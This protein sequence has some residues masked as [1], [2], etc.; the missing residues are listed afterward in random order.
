M[1]SLAEPLP[2]PPRLSRRRS[3]G[4]QGRIA[5]DRLITMLVLAGLLH[6]LIILGVSFTT[7]P[8]RGDGANRGLE[9][10]LVSDELPEARSNDSAT[11]LAQRTQTG[12]G[13]TRERLPAKLPSAARPEAGAAASEA[14]QAAKEE[15]QLLT[16]S[17]VTRTRVHMVPLLPA[18]ALAAQQ[19][20]AAQRAGDQELRLRGEARD[21]LYVTADTRASRLAPYL[22]SWR[23]RVERIGTVNYPTVAQRRGMG[24]NPV[25]EV[26][27]QSD[28]KLKSA[29]ILQ[30]SGHPEID[31]AALDILRLASPFDAFPAELARDYRSL[32][33]AYEWQFGD[34]GTPSGLV[35]IP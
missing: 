9:V 21:E 20:A 32:R 18:E 24:G 1:P 3:D 12:S 29:R 8:V 25:V 16:T 19:P 15:E 6:G 35:T 4:P 23:R 7:P 14:Q 11:Y 27:L 22:D 17:S 13:N 5:R 31:A 34:Q 28:G 26:A 33:F 30:S 2:L 10:L